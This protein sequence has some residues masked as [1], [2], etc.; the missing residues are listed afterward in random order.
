MHVSVTV[1]G[2]RAKDVNSAA[3]QIVGYLHGGTTQGRTVPEAHRS[4]AGSSP[5]GLEATGVGSYFADSAESPGRWRGSGALPEHFDLD[6]AVD[7]VALRRVL[8]GQDPNSGI[9][10]VD[11][12]GSSGRS[13]R[14][15]PNP[16]SS[17]G[18]PTEMLGVTQVAKVVGVDASYIRRVA[19]ET[20]AI[21]AAQ[22]DAARTG[23]D[24]P[25]TPDVFLD[26]TKEPNG[27]WQITRAE[28]NRFAASRN[29]PQVVMGY[30]MTFSVPKSVSALYAVGS[31]EDR[32][33]IDD[34][35]E[36][37]VE[38]G[39]AYI[40]REGFR[41]R[42]QG[43]QEPAGRMV[44]ASYRHYTN[45]ALEPQLHEHVVIA[46]MGTNSLGQTRALDAR[47]LFAHATT[48]GYL[49]GAQLRHQLA[50]NLGLGWQDVHKGL[51]DIDGVGRDV[52]MAI[53]SRRQAVLGLAKE[54]GYFTP[55]ARQKAAL[56]TRPGKEH[57][58]EADELQERWT[59][60][61]SDVGFD[62]QVASALG[63]ST[64]LQ[65]WSPN[66]TEA[67]FTHL[68]SHRGVTEQHAIFDRRDTI[69]AVTTFS[70]DRLSASEIEDLADHWL[71]T[72]ERPTHRGSPIRR[73]VICA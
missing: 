27:R 69:Q 38:A 47:G 68:G 24:T 14:S 39:M 50:E 51:A 43:Q 40:E 67:L 30:D 34:A 65:L 18:D 64:E 8:L 73:L 9:E 61:L 23:A 52:V 54:M 58:V 60:V 32:R 15:D 25:D 19:K 21:R 72:D 48:A 62:R 46:N 31:D 53:S 11:A 28:A 16:G 2:S 29:E 37:G 6:S 41:V 42:R 7:H 22:H 10:L 4:A 35:I 13:Q 44:A 56:A 5:V 20:A 17:Q 33:L 55:A 26:A 12:T 70:N 63:R 3:G 36:S 66:D 45:R 1:L 59:E 49:A 57:G 71:A